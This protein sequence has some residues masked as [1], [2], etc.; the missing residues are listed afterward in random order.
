MEIRVRNYS[1]LYIKRKTNLQWQIQ[2]DRKVPKKCKNGSG[3]FPN[4][5]LILRRLRA[6]HLGRH[7]VNINLKIRLRSSHVPKSA[8]PNDAQRSNRNSRKE[9]DN[10]PKKARI[11]SRT[12]SDVKSEEVNQ[13]RL[14]RTKSASKGHTEAE[15]G[16]K[17]ERP[18]SIIK[19]SNK[20]NLKG[21]RLN[22]KKIW[23]I[24]F[25]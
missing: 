10:S 3:G 11:I 24:L 22:K 9:M 15:R 5:S 12:Q 1:S 19:S 21:I 17:L 25:S 4:D 7:F 6:H 2:Q 20:E 14:G 8:Q 18:K 16:R 23:G 13:G